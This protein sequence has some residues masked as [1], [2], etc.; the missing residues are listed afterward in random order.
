ML[1]VYDPAKVILTSKC[2]GLVT[3][4]FP[5]PS[6][7]LKL[8][9]RVGG[10]LLI[11]TYQ[12]N[13]LPNQ[14][15]NQKH[16]AVNKYD[17]TV[18]IRLFKGFLLGAKR[19]L[20]FEGHPIGLPLDSLNLTDEPHEPRLKF[21]VQGA[22]VQVLFQFTCLECTARAPVEINNCF[23]LANY[24]DW[25]RLRKLN[26]LSLCTMSNFAGSCVG[27]WGQTAEKLNS[28]HWMC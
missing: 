27:P 22:L 15:H 26:S 2:E 19:W 14:K 20:R 10:R 8:G 5:A 13:Y 16:G 18:F 3:N 7:N 9:L 12:S 11:A 6:I 28:T 23:S 25:P 24:E 21:S 4:F 1:S 17:L